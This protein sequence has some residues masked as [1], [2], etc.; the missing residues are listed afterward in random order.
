M[1]S[2]SATVNVRILERDYQVACPA[3]ER[4]ELHAA[5]EYVDRRMKEVRQRGNVI[6]T[7]RV[8]VMAALNIA[9]D[10]LALQ[11]SANAL[12][13][14]DNK[15]EDLTERLESTLSANG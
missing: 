7:D 2:D 8:A 4:D 5:A 1:A 11:E 6:G 10:L 3:D 12:E 9:H 14:V 15:L 13:R